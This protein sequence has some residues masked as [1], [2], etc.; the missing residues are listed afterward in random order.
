MK[1]K[2]S[3][4]F[5]L[6]ACAGSVLA[7]GRD[8]K[9]VIREKASN[10]RVAKAPA[11]KAE[12]DPI[13]FFSSFETKDEWTITDNS[14]T[15]EFNMS[16]GSLQALSAVSGDYYLV[17]GYDSE[18]PRD[19]WA[20]SPAVSLK[21]D[22]KY[23]VS[24]YVYVP[25]YGGNLDSLAI[26]IGTDGTIEAQTK[27]LIQIKESITTWTLV[28]VEYTPTEDG[29]YYFGI[30][31]ATAVADVNAIGVDDFTVSTEEQKPNDPRFDGVS[32]D[33]AAT[34]LLEDGKTIAA[35]ISPSDTSIY[36]QIITSFCD[37]IAIEAIAGSIDSL[38]VDAEG[39]IALEGKYYPDYFLVTG[40][41]DFEVKVKM[42]ASVDA[43]VSIDTV[44][45][46][47]VVA[48]EDDTKA[49]LWSNV[50]IGAEL[51]SASKIVSLQ[52]GYCSA[53]SEGYYLP[54]GQNASI[55]SIALWVS[56]YYVQESNLDSKIRIKFMADNGEYAPDPHAQFAYYDVTYRELF[57]SEAIE[58]NTL[59]G[60]KL[61]PAV[62]VTGDFHIGLDLASP[63]GILNTEDGRDWLNLTI[64]QVS[65]YHGGAYLT[66]EGA[67]ELGAE[68]GWY[69]LYSFF[70]S[71][72]SIALLPNITFTDEDAN[73]T[74]DPE[75]AT[76][77]KTAKADSQL[78]IYPNPA[79]EV[80]YINNLTSDA[81]AT[82]TDVTGKQILSLSH[83]QNSVSVSG[84]SK[85]IY[86]ISI[87]DADGVHTAK[88]VK[89]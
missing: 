26:T 54:E 33:G 72:L 71:S 77:I 56:S 52:G 20:I 24:A 30:H 1:T 10:E 81:S 7:I 37:S 87:K 83:V 74:V 40:I 45:T 47:T 66:T 11:Q 15:A 18:N 79:K 82:V 44:I 17:S 38:F 9:C 84:L 28:Q 78:S 2:I 42:F 43:T 67:D 88:F 23:Y 80:I 86:F 39:N 61:E 12:V 8:A 35:V 68:E 21:K 57:G 36:A 62:V 3:L 89:E 6:V 58:E 27:A 60:I 65:G 69:N 73:E 85:G 48:L 4:L 53:F 41:G 70:G 5:L 32:F 13:V 59:V 50:A 34:Y 64:A 16:L 51:I 75:N 31:H 29:L 55:D 14:E 19:A 46:F 49:H 22:T 76:A 63:D 25:G